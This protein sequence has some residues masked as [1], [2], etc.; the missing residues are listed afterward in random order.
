[1]KIHG[2]VMYVDED[3]TKVHSDICPADCDPKNMHNPEYRAFLHRI[4]DEWLDK[5][6]ASGGLYL[7]QEGH[8]FS[9]ELSLQDTAHEIVA[10]AQILP[11]EG[12]EDTVD[13]VVEILREKTM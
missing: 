13:R 3:G 6:N 4:L 11:N 2:E 10:A 9:D 12:I 5:S 7:V 8:N 1:M